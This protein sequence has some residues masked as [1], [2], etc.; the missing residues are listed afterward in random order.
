MDMNLNEEPE[1]EET[2]VVSIEIRKLE[3][4]ETTMLSTADGN[5]AGD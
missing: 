2:E 4:L 5:P 3:P 1:V